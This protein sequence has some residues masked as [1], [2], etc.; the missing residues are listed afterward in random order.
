MQ[1]THIVLQN[2]SR[3][4]KNLA[5]ASIGLIIG[6]AS[7]V[8]FVALGAGVKSVVL[9]DIFVIRQI[10][11]VPRSY[12]L[13]ITQAS[14]SRIDYRAIEKLS[15]IDHVVRAY[16]KMKFT[17]PAWATGGKE[18]LGKNF[19][20]E[21]VADGIATSL[22]QDMEGHELFR[23]WDAEYTCV[24]EGD[25][26]A[27]SCP[28]GQRCIGGFCRK[29]SCKRSANICK[30]PSYCA[31]DTL[32]CEM[33]VP[34]IANPSLLTVYNSSLTTALKAGDGVRLP[35]LTEQA[36]RGFTFDVELGQSYLGDS[37]Q[38]K[39]FTRRMQVVGFS[40]KAIAVGFTLP[41][42]YVK[43]F[44]AVLTG[45]TQRNVYH[46]VILEADSNEN[47]A[48]I[49]QGVKQLGY[50]L[51]DKHE[52]AERMGLVIS[53]ITLLFSMISLIIVTISAIN[54]AHT[55]FM[56]IAERRREI[57]IMRALGAS[58]NDIRR[59][60]LGES[61]ILGLMGSFLGVM[62]AVLSALLTDYV[63]A[64]YLPD[65]PFK[66]ESFFIFEPRIFAIA[67]V[68]GVAFCIIGAWAPA[69]RAAG[70]DPARAIDN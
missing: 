7:F 41:I 58:R 52:M 46:S 64:R 53:T 48:A 49:S 45:E 68:C 24:G 42:E 18:I 28:E 26:A 27:V 21:V 20:A 66:P 56:I 39:P 9:E 25:G 1:V 54:I 2:F 30:Y 37:A 11:V 23:D 67:I 47:V 32:E 33:P 16:P 8:Y 50:A 62:L 38:G 5:F 44:N 14:F 15:S 29:L 70:M 6:I 13:A 35:K 17:F 51:D 63:S 69:S 31:S 57:G 19:R 55:F 36:I 40:N 43:R 60:I 34:V 3:N 65:F 10:E 22:V 61:L 4:R 12:D 59:M